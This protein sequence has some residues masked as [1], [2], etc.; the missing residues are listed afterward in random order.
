M[1][2]MTLAA[3]IA[4]VAVGLL[5][6]GPS[7]LQV[8]LVIFVMFCVAPLWV[9]GAKKMDEQRRQKLGIE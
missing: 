5:P 9:S 4:G 7:F 1:I 3:I 8:G 6:P 2:R